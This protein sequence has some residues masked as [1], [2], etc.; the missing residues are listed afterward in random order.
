MRGS[1]L[2]NR[3]HGIDWGVS[4]AAV[5]S[6]P[7][8]SG[9][10]LDMYT[11]HAH[12]WLDDVDATFA[13]TPSSFRAVAG[14]GHLQ[15]DG[16]GSWDAAALD[17][18][19]RVLD[20]F[21]E[22]GMRPALTLLH[23][24]MPQWV[25]D[26]GGWLARDTASHFADYAYE[27][28]RRFGDRVS[29]WTT[30]GEMPQ[31][32]IDHVAGMYHLDRGA[33]VT[34]LS[35]LHHLLLGSGLA[36]QALRA[37]DASARVGASTLLMGGYAATQD[38]ADRLA[39]EQLETWAHRL[40]LDP[41]LHGVHLVTDSGN[42]PVADTGC[43]RPGDMEAIATPQDA[44]GLWWHV[45][46]RVA[47]PENLLRVLSPHDRFRALNELN[48]LLA[49]LGFTLIPMDDVE[50]TVYGW[51]VVP[52]AL[53]D[54]VA[55]LYD[56]YDDALPP[57]YIVDN[58]MCDVEPEADAPDATARRRTRL[59]NQLSWLASLMD[60]GVEVR[61]YEYWSILDN[62]EQKF[63][64]SRLYG[65]A[66]PDREHLPQPQIPYDWVHEGAFAT[67]GSAGTGEVA[68]PAPGGRRLRSV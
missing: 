28:G 1:A 2:R 5:I 59:T 42:C 52:E 61:G 64:Y 9:S 63:R 6:A 56:L 24:D 47:A 17:R 19:D 12:R 39:L 37:G 45:P 33:G 46:T 60:Q 15:P 8:A 50:T 66:V 67:H 26:G 3:L 21:A 25:D 7:T 54:A 30:V 11:D 65:V 4:T 40:F 41:M 58:G 23:L 20:F 34:G 51:P 18:C 68:E 43:V 48:S 38:P 35:A 53:A 27:L 31:A 44:L 10:P 32:V 22:A 49:L 14:W 16:P 36:I 57:L 29:R 55:A 62:L 13:A